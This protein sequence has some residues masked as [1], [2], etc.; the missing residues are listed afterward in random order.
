MRH[1]RPVL[2]SCL[3]VA[4]GIGSKGATPAN[5]YFADRIILSGNA[6]TFTGNL[7]GAT[8]EN[9]MEVSGWPIRSDFITQSV[10]WEWTASDQL[11]VTL[12]ITNS[13][14]QSYPQRDG[15]IIYTNQNASFP[16][17]DFPHAPAVAGVVFDAGTPWPCFTFLATSGTTYYIQMN[18]TSGGTHV[19]TLTGTNGP[20][21]IEQPNSQSVLTN[22]SVLFTVMAAGIRPLSYQ[23]SCSGTNLPGQT[24]P[25]LALDGVTASNA[26]AYFVVVSN[27]TGVMTSKVANLVVSDTETKPSLRGLRG[28]PTNL[29][30][31]MING[32][33]G[34]F[35]RIETSTNFF[36]WSPELNFFNRNSSRLDFYPNF[37]SVIFNS[38]QETPLAVN[39]NSKRKFV[40]A[41]VYLPTNAVC[42]SNLRQVRYAKH[43]WAWEKGRTGSDSASDSEL[44]PYLR[45]WKFGV[46]CP[47]GG[48]YVTQTIRNVPTCSITN[49]VLEEPR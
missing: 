7:A 42:N 46:R 18:G 17:N 24:Y 40:R 38:E 37:T 36:D 2:L 35:Y 20:V 39:V 32:E 1:F 12:Q 41:S 28:S 15:L 27:V 4:A 10:W 26:G 49:H 47:E 31:F 34:R 14:N 5:N 3:F 6:L 8:L 30:A 25:M 23:W 16:T 33:T 11:V 21:I 19:M 44:T 43:M 45:N 9:W 48:T 29:F 13:F 22:D